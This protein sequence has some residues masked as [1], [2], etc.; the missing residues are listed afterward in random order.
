MGVW[1]G[2]GGTQAIVTNFGI[3]LATT[4]CGLMLRVAYHQM[5]EDP[6]EVERQVQIEL[7][8]AASKLRGEL[9]SSITTFKLL[10]TA[11]KQTLEEST[12]GATTYVSQVVAQ[13]SALYAKASEDVAKLTQA[14]SGELE[15]FQASIEEAVVKVSKSLDQLGQ[16]FDTVRFPTDH[17]TRQMQ[18]VAS[19]VEMFAEQVGALIASEEARMMRLEAVLAEAETCVRRYSAHLSTPGS[20]INGAS[21]NN[22][23]AGL[24][25]VFGAAKA[26]IRL[27]TRRFMSKLGRRF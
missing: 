23:G 24:S 19:V 8:N 1:L 14:N 10:S 12:N 2:A 13:T 20:E 3:A 17:I 11:I 21:L 22:R 15:R 26:A 27:C 25:K 6:F 7:S 9:L 5:R 4:I 18:A 16:R